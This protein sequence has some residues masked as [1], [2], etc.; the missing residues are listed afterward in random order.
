MTNKL[1]TYL[2]ILMICSFKTGLNDTIKN[3]QFKDC[4]KD[5][6]VEH[7]CFIR[8]HT[9]NKSITTKINKGMYLT[10][11]NKISN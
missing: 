2:V 3:R 4:E 8:V 6:K 10:T 11:A 7:N 1:I 9:A 5:I